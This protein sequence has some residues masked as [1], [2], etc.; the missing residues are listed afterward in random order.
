MKFSLRFRFGVGVGIEPSTFHLGRQGLDMVISAM[1][2]DTLKK[3]KLQKEFSGITKLVIVSSNVDVTTE[4]CRK[5]DSQHCVTA[6]LFC[7]NL[8]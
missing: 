3:Q 2:L 7:Y 5:K 1:Q 6:P 4:Y 8:S